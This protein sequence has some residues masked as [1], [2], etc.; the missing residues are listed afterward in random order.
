MLPEK[1]SIVVFDIDGT[2]TDSVRVHQTAFEAALRGFGFPDLRTDWSSY[3]HHSDSA[4]FGEAWQEAGFA[5]SPDFG[6]LED[7]FRAAFSRA[8]RLDPIREIPGS[9]GLLAALTRSDWVPAFAT[10][11]LRSAAEYKLGVLTVPCDRDLL[12]TASE[13]RTREEIV[14]AAIHRAARKYGLSRD[15]RVVSVG[16]G[17]W[18]LLTAR[19]LGLEFIGVGRGAGA[20][21]LRAHGAEVVPDLTMGAGLLAG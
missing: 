21:V 8:C 19:T 18:D 17:V 2:L 12:V 6:S 1:T 15:A 10:G 7:R 16:D 4:I 9:S 20:A 13:Y 5:G 3:R 11:S 14:S